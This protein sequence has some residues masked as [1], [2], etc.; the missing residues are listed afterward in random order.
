MARKPNV[1]PL[2]EE[3]TFEEEGLD[4]RTLIT[5]T[6][7]KGIITFAS[8]AYR[9]MTKYTKSDLIGTSHNIVRHPDMPEVAFREMWE[10][11]QKGKEWEGYVKNLRK[12]GKYYWVIVKI[13]PIDKDGNV[14]IEKPDKIAGYTAVRKEPNAVEL[15]KIKKMYL[16]IRKAELIAKKNLK[17]WEKE[18]LERLEKGII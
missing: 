14:V 10:E 3:A 16:K 11:I 8:P 15:Q 13:Y 2:N 12:D 5:R 1:Q 18:T 17:D 4:A 7:L 6:D 9:K